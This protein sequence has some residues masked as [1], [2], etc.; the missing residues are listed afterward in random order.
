[1]PQDKVVPLRE[2]VARFVPD[3]ASVCMSTALEAVIST[4]G[5]EAREAVRVMK[6]RLSEPLDYGA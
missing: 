1:V 5:P 6:P 3:V 2:A 4:L